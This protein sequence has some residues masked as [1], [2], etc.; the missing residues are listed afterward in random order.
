M[1]PFL[2]EGVALAA[3]LAAFFSFLARFLFLMSSGVW[4]LL[5]MCG[6]KLWEGGKGKAYLLP[7]P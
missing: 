2:F 3:A 1:A 6:K 7:R 4:S 5:D